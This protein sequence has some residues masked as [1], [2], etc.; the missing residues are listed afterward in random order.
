MA[1]LS[2]NAYLTNSQWSLK[3][4][5]EKKGRP[6]QLNLNIT[7]V[8]TVLWQVTKMQAASTSTI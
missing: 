7:D 6:H 4:S 5:D 1:D 2:N 3:K 8:L